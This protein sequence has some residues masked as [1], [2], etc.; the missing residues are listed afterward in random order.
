MFV[1]RMSKHVQFVLCNILPAVMS[2][3]KSRASSTIAVAAEA[4]AGYDL[5]PIRQA[6]PAYM[7][8]SYM[9]SEHKQTCSA[10]QK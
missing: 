9:V 2:V 10:K 6:G 8:T 5:Q 1:R 4:K 3:T 7:H